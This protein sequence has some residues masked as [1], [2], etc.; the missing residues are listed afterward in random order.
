MAK[1]GKSNPLMISIAE[2]VGATVGLI[3]AKT[4]DAVE[5]ASKL[6]DGAAKSLTSAKPVPKRRPKTSAKRKPAVVKKAV[7]KKPA[8]KAP[9]ARKRAAKKK[10]K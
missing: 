8:K 5:G 7:K 4:S 10:K 2:K 9:V 1:P 6:V 3:V